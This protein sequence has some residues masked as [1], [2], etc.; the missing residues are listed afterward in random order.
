MMPYK[1]TSQYNLH[2][3]DT[4]SLYISFKNKLDQ[5][6]FESKYV[7]PYKLGYLKIENSKENNQY[8]PYE[9]FYFLSP[10]FYVAILNNKIDFSKTKIRGLQKK[11]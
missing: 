8:I 3:T 4:D 6:N 1:N 9:R 7:D 11:L 5:L 2:Y 10:K